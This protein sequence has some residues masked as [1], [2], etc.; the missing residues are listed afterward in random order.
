M[1]SAKEKNKAEK[2]DGKYQQ[3]RTGLANLDIVAESH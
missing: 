3:G 2:E 1:V